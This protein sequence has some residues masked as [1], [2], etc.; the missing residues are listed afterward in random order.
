MRFVG[1]VLDLLWPARCAACDVESGSPLCAVCAVSLVPPEPGGHR[2]RGK[3]PWTTA[4]AQHAYGGQL[5]LAIRRA[6]RDIVAARARTLGRLL[7]L[8]AGA[9]DLIV[10]VPLHPRRLRARG[11]NVAA[12]LVRGAGHPP[13]LHVLA[14]TR[15]TPAQAGLPLRK[16][17]A[18][19]RRAFTASAKVRDQRILL[20]DD[21]WTTGATLTACA[22]ALRRAG[23]REIHVR[24]LARTPA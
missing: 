19:V 11:F 14:R 23:A 17:L 10:P 5:A 3:P 1:E 8:P 2:P 6:K 18:N 13:C 21:V 7:E 20:V 24:T 12:E 9:A 22:I 4:T 15:D 16:R